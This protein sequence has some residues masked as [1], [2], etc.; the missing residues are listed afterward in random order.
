[1]KLRYV[2]AWIAERNVDMDTDTGDLTVT[3]DLQLDTD[4]GPL[5]LVFTPEAAANIGWDL[6]GEGAGFAY[7]D[8]LG[9]DE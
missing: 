2:H 6:I 9:R 5:A 7:N 1:M 3:V 8:K 4:R